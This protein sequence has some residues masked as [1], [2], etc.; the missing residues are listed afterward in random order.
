MP[1]NDFTSIMSSI[2]AGLTGDAKHDIAYLM[3]QAEAYKDHPLAKEVAREC[4]RM[5][6]DLMP[7]DAKAEFDQALDDD[8]ADLHEA[9]E[10]AH[11]L[12]GEGRVEEALAVLEP[13]ARRL[14]DLLASGWFAD[15]SQ[16]VYLDFD[17]MTDYAVW[18][19]HTTETR[20]ARMVTQPIA[21][22]YMAYGS[23][24]YDLGRYAEAVEALHKAI[25]WNPASAQ[26]RFELAENYKRLGYIGAC[27]AALEAAYPCVANG[28]QMAKWHRERAFVAVERG[29]LELAAAHLVASMAFEPSDLAVQEML[30]IC[31]KFGRDFSQMS[32][33]A[34]VRV[35]EERGRPV[36]ADAD[37]IAALADLVA[38][39]R[40]E[41]Q[42]A[43]AASV[44]GDVYDLTGDETARRAAE[45]LRAQA[46]E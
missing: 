23:C 44:A 45:E 15:D 46:G 6:W 29:Q 2:T 12:C 37:T 31:E 33:G 20:E 41:G 24:L 39:L 34:A 22:V 7:E 25:R 26:L 40:D 10:K 1:T 5:M 38:V 43:E 16:S 14:D 21:V 8:G 19:A 13:Q 9:M 32:G 11:Q 35:L 27:E 28:A 42:L 36:T 18:H 3:S 17:D 30:Y 4:G